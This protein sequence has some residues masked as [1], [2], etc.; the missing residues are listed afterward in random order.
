[1]LI[2]R[3]VDLLPLHEVTYRYPKTGG[4]ITSAVFPVLR[5]Y[6]TFPALSSMGLSAL[7]V[8]SDMQGREPEP[9][10]GRY[11]QRLLGELVAEEI[12]ALS[13]LGELP[14]SNSIGV[15]LAGDLF[16]TEDLGKRGGKGDVRDVW[17][18]FRNRFR[19]VA[20]V[21][22]NHD[23]FGDGITP[24]QEFVAMPGIHYLDPGI[25]ELDGIRIGGV[26]GI[27]GNPAR[28]FRRE[29]RDFLEAIERV[30]EQSPDV[31]ILHEGP[32]GSTSDR[33]GNQEVRNLLELLP[34]ALVIC[35]H[36]HW[37][38]SRWEEL[39]NGTQILNSDARRYLFLCE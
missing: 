12:Q 6:G 22:G 17:L 21:P 36:S 1:M 26:G 5:A 37:D 38:E 28:P 10:S 18:A 32:S 9:S 16:V 25:V 20:G 11:K 31:I 24:D 27:V 7:L 33:K 23:R 4:T 39:K 2:I 35:G 13:E 3:Q 14:Q 15:L 34:P 8:A 30:A 29:L 19:W